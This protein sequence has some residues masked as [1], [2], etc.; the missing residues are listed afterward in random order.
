ML[1]LALLYK[2]LLVQLSKHVSHLTSIFSPI[3]PCST[4]N[5]WSTQSGFLWM[6]VTMMAMT[7]LLFLIR[8]P[9]WGGMITTGDPNMSEEDYYIKVSSALQYTHTRLLDAL[10]VAFKHF[11]DKSDVEERELYISGPDLL[12]NSYFP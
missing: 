10:Q 2:T 11:S 12:F 5:P 7:L 4:T 8:F 1:V 3:V 9:M 6:G